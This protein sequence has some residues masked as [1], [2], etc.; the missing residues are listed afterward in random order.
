MKEESIEYIC[1]GH[2]TQACEHCKYDEH[3]KDCYWYSPIRI[4]VY[5][6]NKKEEKK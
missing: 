6:V 2:I 3:N 1:L 5:Q 4:L